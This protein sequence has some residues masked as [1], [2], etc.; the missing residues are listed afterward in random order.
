MWGPIFKRK[1]PWQVD[2]WIQTQEE[3]PSKSKSRMGTHLAIPILQTYKGNW[4]HE[5]KS[6][7]F[8]QKWTNVH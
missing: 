6:Q 2:R 4:E 8:G 7:N 1:G 5:S 3:K